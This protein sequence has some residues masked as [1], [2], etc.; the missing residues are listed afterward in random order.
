[1]FILQRWN[2][3]VFVI[4]KPNVCKPDSE[5]NST[6][7]CIT[8]KLPYYMLQYFLQKNEVWLEIY[9]RCPIWPPLASDIGDKE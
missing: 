3:Y 7:I 6:L 2:K 8:R 1:M 4:L 5:I 9:S